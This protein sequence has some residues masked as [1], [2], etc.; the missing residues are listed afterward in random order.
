MNEKYEIKL[1]NS[2]EA[3]AFKNMTYG[4][5]KPFIAWMDNVLGKLFAVGLYY[6]KKPAGSLLG[7][8]LTAGQKIDIMSIFIEKEH[9]GQKIALEMMKFLEEKC[10]EHKVPLMSTFYFENRPFVPLINNILDKCGFAPIEPE[11]YFCKCDANF[12]KM[13]IIEYTGLPHGFETFSWTGLSPMLKEKLRREWEDKE[14]FDKR[15]SPFNDE[16]TIVPEISLGLKKDGEIAG[17]AI[18][19]YYNNDTIIYTSIFIM[20]QYQGAT[21]GI[22]LQM[23]SIRGH[24]L[25]DLAQKYPYA[26]FNVRYDNP[27]RLKMVKKKFAKYSIESY[28]QVIRKKVL[29]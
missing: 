9:R 27:A 18:C 29:I 11:V 10:R 26:L 5:Y 2:S 14:W 22:A 13:P 24:L 7:L 25:T 3:E 15:L 28:D 12:A 21:L 8:F 19:N 6:E 20:P 23:L 17:W 1:L 4:Q 16:A